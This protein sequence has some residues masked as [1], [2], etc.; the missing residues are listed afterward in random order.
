MYHIIRIS[1]FYFQKL[2]I[3]K[4]ASDDVTEIDVP[5][6]KTEATYH[7]MK[8]GVTYEIGVFAYTG[9]QTGSSSN[10]MRIAVEADKTD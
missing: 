3:H 10:K 5:A 6:D 4:D 9:K 1:I 8:K 2:D 7:G